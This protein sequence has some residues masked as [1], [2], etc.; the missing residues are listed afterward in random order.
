[1]ELKLEAVSSGYGRNLILNNIS[2][3]IDCSGSVGIIGQNGSGKTTLLKTISGLLP[4]TGSIRLAGRELSKMKPKEA[5]SLI[6]VMPQFSNTYFS[7]TVEE[8]VMM[9]RYIHSRGF[10][11]GCAPDDRRR[12]TEVL[13]LL[14]LMN[15][16]DKCLTNLSGG[17]LQRVLLARTL[18]QDTPIIIL[19]EPTNHL[20][21]RYQAE[22]T[23][24]LK[25]WLS[26]DKKHTL[27]GVYH[28]LPTALRLSD[29][30]IVMKNGQV[31]ADQ[32]SPKE[33]KRD[34]LVKAFD[35][36]AAQLITE[37]LELLNSIK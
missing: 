10:L 26:L 36:D 8:T 20:D 37:N 31:I 34:I 28:D 6:A 11:S 22:L 5:A 18:V 25:N 12:T 23:E 17:Q 4:Y 30:L 19:D 21:I 13:E 24:H 33:I 9:G 1:M 2:L 14:N 27:I 15:V 16:K 7:Y 29:R 3:S 35:I 32:H